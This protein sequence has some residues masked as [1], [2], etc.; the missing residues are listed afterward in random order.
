MKSLWD[1]WE[2]LGIEILK[3]QEQRLELR[4]QLLDRIG[5]FDAGR[6]TKREKEVLSILS[7][8]PGIRNKEIGARLFISER[9]VKLH[10]S[11]M[12]RKYE[13]ESRYDLVA[14]TSNGQRSNN[15][16]VNGN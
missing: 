9:T 11:S 13:V 2:E 8:D 15:E 10:V 4:Q 16:T 3:L 1:K 5:A 12:L 14:I 6:L 7:T